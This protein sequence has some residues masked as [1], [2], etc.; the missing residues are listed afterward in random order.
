M[1]YL[2]YQLLKKDTV[3]YSY[4]L[5]LVRNHYLLANVPIQD[6]SLII[7][8]QMYFTTEEE[9]YRETLLSTILGS[10]DYDILACLLV[11]DAQ[12]MEKV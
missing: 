11:N 2:V 5:N 1:E 4:L 7:K 12:T 10:L 9:D 3:F 6:L 8:G